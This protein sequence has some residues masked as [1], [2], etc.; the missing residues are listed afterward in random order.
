MF[1]AARLYHVEGTPIKLKRFVISTHTAQ[2]AC[3]LVIYRSGCGSVIDMLL[4]ETPYRSKMMLLELRWVSL[5][6]Q[7]IGL[8]IILV[9]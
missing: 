3:N 7:G 1:I 2:P 5:Y 4:F 8:C 9:K 6:E